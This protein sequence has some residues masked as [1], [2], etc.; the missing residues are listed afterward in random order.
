[1]Q[2]NDQDYALIFANF[3][4]TALGVWIAQVAINA[5]ADSLVSSSIAKCVH[6]TLLLLAGI[7]ASMGDFITISVIGAIIITFALDYTN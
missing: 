4:H 2:I 5:D 1:M 6:A 7:L 3:Q